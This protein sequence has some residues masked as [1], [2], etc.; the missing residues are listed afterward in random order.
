MNGK[1][2]NGDRKHPKL[3]KTLE[4][5]EERER[6]FVC[7]LCALLFVRVLRGLGCRRRRRRCCHC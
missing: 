5:L 1:T 3:C 7:A 2:D 6:L 4:V